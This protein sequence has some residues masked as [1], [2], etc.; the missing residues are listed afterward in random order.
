M[1]FT[2]CSKEDV[3]YQLTVKENAHAQK[4]DAVLKLLSALGITSDHVYQW[5]LLLK[6][7]GPKIVNIKGIQ[8]TVANAISRLDFCLIKDEK[9]NWMRSMKCC[10]HYTVHARAEESTHDH[11]NQ[12]N[13]VFTNRSKEDV[14]YPVTV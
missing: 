14:I 12:M 10:C 5:R 9:D 2:N 6:E 8:N 4:D 3:I 13:M 11:Q 1:L 7:Y